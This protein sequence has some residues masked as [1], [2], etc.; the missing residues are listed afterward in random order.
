M[1]PPL[2]ILMWFVALMKAE[3]LLPSFG[4]SAVQRAALHR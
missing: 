4:L 3:N 1:A 2:K